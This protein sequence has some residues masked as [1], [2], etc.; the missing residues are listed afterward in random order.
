MQGVVSQ[1]VFQSGVSLVDISRYYPAS[2]RTCDTTPCIALVLRLV[3]TSTIIASDFFANQGNFT[4]EYIRLSRE[5]NAEW[6]KK[7]AEG[8]GDICATLH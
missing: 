1:V 5:I 4:Q 2:I 8:W 7:T 3:N 6:R